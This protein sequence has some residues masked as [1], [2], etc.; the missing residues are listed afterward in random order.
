[1]S[2]SLI[3][4]QMVANRVQSDYLAFTGSGLLT[5]QM[6]LA[7]DSREG[8]SIDKAESALFRELDRIR[9]EVPTEGEMA[10]ARTLLEKRFLDEKATYIGRA[11]ALAR[12]EA[13]GA[14]LRGAPDYQ[15]RIRAVSAE[16]VQRAAAKYLTLANTSIHEYE[17]FSAA[18]R[19]FSADTFATTVAALAPEFARPVESASARPADANTSL[20]PVPQGRERSPEQRAM[21][22]SIQPLPLRDFSTL[23]G[24][25]AFVRE[26]HSIPVVTVAILFQGGRLVE[27][28]TTSG[29]T[30]LMLRSILYGTPRRS[31]LQVTE[32]LEQLGGDVRLVVE[33]D[34][35]GFMLNV[36][37]R[38]ADRTL[39]LLRDAIEDP[40]FRDDDVARARL[41][42]IAANRDARDSSFERSRELLFRG[43]FPGHSYSLP[44]H[45]REEIVATLTSQ[46]LKDWHAQTIK[47]QVPLAIIVGD[48]DGSALVSSQL[49]EGFK[50]RE[51]DS[52][53]Q[54]KT[55]QPASGAEKIEQRRREQTTVAIGLAGPKAGSGDLIALQL[56]ESAMNGKV[57]RFFREL[58]DKENLVWASALGVDAMFVAGAII[59]YGVTAGENEARARAA[60]LAELDKLAR[61]GLTA[62]ELTSERALL[63]TSRIALLQEH[64]QH[65]IQYARA[66]FY[67]KQASEVD[68]FSEL[69]TRVSLE[70]T[71]RVAS[72]Y[73]KTPSACAAIVRGT[74]RTPLP[75]QPKQ[76]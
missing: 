22:E 11:Q 73:F 10:R 18:A 24:P 33:P 35:F 63:A 32:E 13:A 28:E 64:S 46:K 38:N 71:K 15:V 8:V 25:R 20:A 26:D 43:L 17:P 21:I 52:V 30:E 47:R 72:S 55:P 76:D 66:V 7:T 41:G 75:S 3:E 59:A 60:L 1:L 9:R 31:F 50:R 49:A 56:I 53:I 54:V 16:E 27:D 12:S 57:G 68:S 39:K 67:G 51:A 4:G 45:G 5:L 48:T 29:T 14:G 40:A 23:N 62:D 6:W 44:P 34:F 74:S 37:S 69:V 58:R 70:D 2:R 42:Q 65:A 61:S 36:L 19:P